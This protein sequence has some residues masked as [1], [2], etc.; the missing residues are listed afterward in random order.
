MATTTINR[1]RGDTKDLVLFL[2]DKDD[3][4]FDITGATATFSV[5][6]DKDPSTANYKFQSSATI[7]IAAGS[8][9]FEFTDIQVDLVGNF[10]YDVQLLDV[11]GKKS[12]IL[13]G[14][15]KFEQDITKD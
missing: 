3:E 10:F 8:L 6:E 4:I 1:F 14:K 7:D 13:K 9:T 2:T 15:I 5:S 11:A 12:T